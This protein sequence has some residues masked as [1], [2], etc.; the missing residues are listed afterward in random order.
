MEWI[1]MR[2]ISDAKRR[3]ASRALDAVR[4]KTRV[5][6]Q[7]IRAVDFLAAWCAAADLW[8]ALSCAEALVGTEGD[9]LT[10]A[11]RSLREVRAVADPLLAI[12]PVP[13]PA[14]ISVECS[15]SQAARASA[16]RDAELRWRAARGGLA[17]SA[18]FGAA[19]DGVLAA[20]RRRG[21]PSGFGIRDNADA[22]E[23]LLRDLACDAGRQGASS[24]R[25]SRATS[26]GSA[27]VRRG[28]R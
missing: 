20:P 12:A 17:I 10:E 9:D 16:W 13:G 24:A 6:A 28:K 4:S 25:R 26:S 15:T 23:A 14:V 27:A 8:K 7:A 21:R 11:A 19:A 22:V 18:P 3:R 5:L 2:R 1:S